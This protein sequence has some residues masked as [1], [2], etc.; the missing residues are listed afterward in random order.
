MKAAGRIPEH[1]TLRWKK[2]KDGKVFHKKEEE[3][4]EEGGRGDTCH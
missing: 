3:E 1:S 2:Q 4:K